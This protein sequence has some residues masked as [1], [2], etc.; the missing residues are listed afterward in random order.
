MTDCGLL[1]SLINRACSIWG[2]CQDS[3]SICI[4]RS[5]CISNNRCINSNRSTSMVSLRRTTRPNRHIPSVPCHPS[6]WDRIC[7]RSRHSSWDQMCLRLCQ[8]GMRCRLIIGMRRIGSRLVEKCCL[9]GYFVSIGY[10][11][12]SR[13]EDDLI[14]ESSVTRMYLEQR[15]NSLKSDLK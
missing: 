9:I 11:V 3:S 10:D 7:R 14:A 8:T 6:R 1:V 13:G 15:I 12:F 5:R 4:N 2:R